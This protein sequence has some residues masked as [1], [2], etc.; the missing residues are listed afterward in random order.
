MFRSFDPDHNGDLDVPDPY[1][2][3]GRGFE[4]V[5]E[6]VN[7]TCPPLPRIYQAGIALTG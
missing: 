7:R 2:G 3:G 1:Y 4:D 6:I 5:F